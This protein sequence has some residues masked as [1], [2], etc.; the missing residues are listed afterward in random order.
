MLEILTRSGDTAEAHPNFDRKQAI[1][2]RIVN[3]KLAA[4]GIVVPL[5]EP[6]DEAI[7]S[8][9]LAFFYDAMTKTTAS[10]EP[11]VETY[12]AWANEYLDGVIAGTNIVEGAEPVTVPVAV[13]NEGG[14]LGGNFRDT[15]Y[16][17]LDD[18]ASDVNFVL[19]PLGAYTRE[20]I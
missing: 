9:A 10:R 5:E 17:D 20:E 19:P 7:R 3:N 11:W 6:I 14:S 4:A 13:G 2:D 12:A 16:F 1:A 15:F 18:P 8:C